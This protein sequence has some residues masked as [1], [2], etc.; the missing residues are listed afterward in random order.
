MRVCS[1][2]HGD[3]LHLVLEFGDA[4][5]AQSAAEVKRRASKLIDGSADVVIDLSSVEFVDSI[6]LGV[7]ISLFKAVRT[8][9]REAKFIG[10]R[11]GVLRV[12]QIIRLDEIFDLQPN[13]EPAAP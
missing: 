12:L 7:L 8:A 5:D 1:R 13:L 9:G 4:L 3:V 11:P 6:G 10:V 2:R